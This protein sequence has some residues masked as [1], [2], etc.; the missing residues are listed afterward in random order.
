MFYFGIY[1]ILFCCLKNLNILFEILYYL[2]PTHQFFYLRIGNITNK[3]FWKK[4][5]DVL[6]LQNK[7]HNQH[8]DTYLIFCCLKIG[9]TIYLV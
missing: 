1:F 6:F 7:Q 8:P 9:A 5:K 3:F 4:V 2:M